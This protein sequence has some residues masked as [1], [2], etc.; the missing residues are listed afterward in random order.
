MIFMLLLSLVTAQVALTTTTPCTI[1]STT[2]PIVSVE[3][4]SCDNPC[5]TIESPDFGA[6][7]Y[8]PDL[9]IDHFIYTLNQ[10]TGIKV[11]FIDTFD[12]IGKPNRC[13]KAGDDFLEIRKVRENF[14]KRFCNRLDEDWLP[15]PVD[16]EGGP[17]NI[18]FSSESDS[19]TGQ[20]FKLEVCATGCPCCD[21]A[22]DTCK[23]KSE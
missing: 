3:T 21:P 4:L 5:V 18:H 2:S 19:V 20:G 16:I 15:P 11:S 9:S 8:A 6:T 14:K 1:P 10:C 12:V 17:I 22:A 7:N 13:K 23:N